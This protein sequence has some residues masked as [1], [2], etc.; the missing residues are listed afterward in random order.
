MSLDPRTILLSQNKKIVSKWMEKH[1]TEYIKT[2]K[3]L[4]ERLIQEYETRYADQGYFKVESVVRKKLIQSF[5]ELEDQVPS[6]EVYVSSNR[7]RTWKE[8]KFPDQQ[9]ILETVFFTQ[10]LNRLL[11]GIRLTEN[12]VSCT[13]GWLNRYRTGESIPEHKD[14]SGDHQIILGLQ[15]PNPGTSNGL[16]FVDGNRLHLGPGD[17]LVFKAH[18]L[19][20]RTKPNENSEAPDRINAVLRIYE[21]NNSRD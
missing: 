13:E 10:P 20:H 8:Y 7:T 19:P 14:T 2:S 17:V 18:E 15:T 16:L 12:R 4:E 9:N 6:R 11:K 21:S 3:K 5:L 1:L